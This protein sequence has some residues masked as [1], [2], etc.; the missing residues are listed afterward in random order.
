MAFQRRSFRNVAVAISLLTFSSSDPAIG[1]VAPAD[2]QVPAAS[3]EESLSRSV[4]GFQVPGI[5]MAVVR[6]GKVD[7]ISAVGTTRTG[8]K[9]RVDHHT[10][11]PIGSNTKAFTATLIA[12]LVDE[13]RLKWDDRVSM[14]LPWVRFSDSYVTENVTI[15]DL[16]AMRTG[17]AS[18]LIWLGSDSDSAAVLSRLPAIKPSAGF[19]SRYVYSNINYLIAGRIAEKVTGKSWAE[20]V[21]QRLFLPL[22]M[23]DSSIG[24][25]GLAAQN[26]VSSHALVHGKVYAIKHTDTSAVAPAGS[27]N[28][29][30]ADMAKWVQF[31]L[32]GKAADG[33][34][35]LSSTALAEMQIPQMLMDGFSSYG[36]AW[37]LFPT[38][39]GTANKWATHDG[40]T[41]GAV[42]TVAYAP[43]KGLG[44]VVLGNRA[45]TDMSQA[46]MLQ[47]MDGL[48]GATPKDH[49]A[50]AISERP[51][52]VEPAALRTEA[53]PLEWAAYTGR[54][55]DPVLGPLTAFV[56]NGRLVIKRGRWVGDAYV[57]EG[58]AFTIVWRDPLFAALGRDT[59]TYEIEGDRP[60]AL[61]VFGG[62]FIRH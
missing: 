25:Q 2:C 40:S 9:Q 1:L 59:A 42:S 21:Q 23:A 41:L 49:V 5:A 54:F 47:A 31:Q 46:L 58:H 27:I 26:S 50:A 48:L 17:V 12:L 53:P 22:G 29:S 7:F 20:L 33:T 60:V 51:K 35:L 11:F 4:A 32:T 3:L 18:D 52:V 36:F 19:R 61:R 28:S 34:Q 62:R 24:L 15:R 30:V 43:G 37:Q 10:L 57:K 6:D 16:L 13:G 56:Q 55:D 14:H 45:D 44:V 38:Y 39:R 8:G